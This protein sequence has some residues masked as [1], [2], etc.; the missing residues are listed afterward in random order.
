MYCLDRNDPDRKRASS[1][2]RKALGKECL[3]VL[4]TIATSAAIRL[5]ELKADFDIVVIDEA[6]HKVKPELLKY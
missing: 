1:A 4:T 6:G 2:A 3:V 5:K